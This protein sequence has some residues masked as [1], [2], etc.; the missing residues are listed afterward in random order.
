MKSLSDNISF[1]RISQLLKKE[2]FEKRKVLI[3]RSIILIAILTSATL[4]IGVSNNYHYENIT[5][6]IDNSPSGKYTPIAYECYHDY[7]FQINGVPTDHAINDSIIFFLF[8]FP[9]TMALSASFAFEGMSSKR[10]KISFLMTPATTL[11]KYISQFIIYIFGT[12]I[13]FIIG[14]IIADFVRFL[15]FSAIYP[16][17]GI[18]QM[19]PSHYI[20]ELLFDS[21][22]YNTF[23]DNPANLYLLITMFSTSLFFLGSTIWPRFSFVKTFGALSAIFFSNLLLAMSILAKDP[24]FELIFDDATTAIT[25]V[26]LALAIASIFCF[27]LA[28]YRLKESEI[29]QRM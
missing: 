1:T 3:L 12:S 13:I 27:T 22:F 11:E 9:I 5:E 18:I 21:N 17:Y 23:A 28:Y 14:C 2:F 29:I 10:K 8:A 7:N 20:V 16:G 24:L 4:F 26:L 19:I 6:E 15:I 25:I